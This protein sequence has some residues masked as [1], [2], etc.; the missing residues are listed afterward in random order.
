MEWAKGL[1]S[2]RKSSDCTNKRH[3]E[4]LNIKH[5]CIKKMFLRFIL[6]SMH[7]S[8]VKVW[9][10]ILSDACSAMASLFFS[11]T[12]LFGHM[13]W[14][15]SFRGDTGGPGYG[16]GGPACSNDNLWFAACSTGYKEASDC[17]RLGLAASTATS[18]RNKPNV[19]IL[20]KEIFIQHK[21]VFFSICL[22]TCWETV[23]ILFFKSIYIYTN[24]EGEEE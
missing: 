15:P 6:K 17:R 1:E 23:L 7:T 4:I 24:F 8:L 19:L 11:R 13:P 22:G 20:Q 5:A 2:W 9:D 18:T 12:C 10:P 3:G 21:V 16:A 14:I